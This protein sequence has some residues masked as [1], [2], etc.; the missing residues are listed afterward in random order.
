[1]T[2]KLSKFIHFKVL[3]IDPFKLT[4]FLNNFKDSKK[5]TLI[6]KALIFKNCG[7]K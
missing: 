1:M 7:N 3:G 6:S 5:N 4:E 2:S